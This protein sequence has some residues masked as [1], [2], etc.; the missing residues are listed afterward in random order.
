MST[1][2]G[3]LDSGVGGLSVLQHIHRLLPDNPTLYF[4]DQQ[5]VPYGP[6]PAHEID[7]Y[8][9]AIA[10]FL[11][12]QGARVIVV[13]CHAASAASLYHLRASYP[14]VP[15]VGIEPAVKPA[16]ASTRSGV[17]GVLTTQATA[18]GQL[19]RQV[20]ERFAVGVQVLTRPAPDLV[21]IVEQGNQQTAAGRAA[22]RRH[23][24]AL[25]AAGAD[26]IVLACTHFPFLADEIRALAG[27]GVTLVDPGPAVARRVAQ[28]LPCPVADNGA[29]AATDASHH[30][31]TSGDPVHFGELLALLLGEA[32]PVT[33]VEWLPESGAYGILTS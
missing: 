6:R 7:A 1:S 12:G 22:L 10:R 24:A 26:Q 8:V 13:A 15:F 33:G 21:Q 11:L 30:Y 29:V 18:D 9:T 27:P 23:V 19:Y 28:V 20:L 5:H 3:V 2:I 14:D 16:A 17:V 31:Y 25:T 4:A 32:E